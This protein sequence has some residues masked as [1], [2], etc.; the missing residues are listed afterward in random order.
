MVEMQTAAATATSVG[1]NSWLRP[2]E[3][4]EP[5]RD[6]SIIANGSAVDRM[7]ETQMRRLG[8]EAPN[9]LAG[10]RVMV[11]GGTGCVG[12]AVIARLS[13]LTPRPLIVSVSRG[14]TTPRPEYLH[15]QYEIGD[16]R[17]L[18]TMRRL[19]DRHRPDVILHLAAQ[20][21][22]GQAERR[23]LETVD[24]N[25]RGLANV[26]EAAKKAGVGRVVAASTGKAF[27][28]M[29]YD[30]YAFTKQLGEYVLAGASQNLDVA[31]ARFT[32]I[33]DNSLIWRKLHQWTRAGDPVLLHSKNAFYVQS[34]MEAADLL[35]ALTD[36]GNGVGL[37]IAAQRDLGESVELVRL[38]ADVRHRNRS[39]S[40]IEIV[41]HERGY[42]EGFYAGTY[43]VL[44]AGDH[45]P[46][47]NAI[48]V[49]ATDATD[50]DAQP[51]DVAVRPA[52]DQ[53]EG[54][55]EEFL[56]R[57]VAQSDEAALRDGIVKIS[58][59]L[60]AWRLQGA[61]PSTVERAI[62]AAARDELGPLHLAIDAVLREFVIST[63]S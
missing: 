37:R 15:V 26:I 14:L 10:M 61:R 9:H 27:R 7:I 49:D 40:P 42:E 13:K 52:G 6:L 43:D 16:V 30:V 39:Q 45:S 56:E 23:P 57:T 12:A 19:V 62:R 32:H 22:P 18:E 48:E 44:T 54:L 31:V 2:A 11:I 8:V 24:V 51:Y 33:V 28:L 58:P 21:D 38:A 29:T 63:Q 34:A 4:I 20:R 1:P 59:A 60:L 35:L 53:P 17:S 46:L 47:L 50:A 55:I 3:V 36:G 25:V 41:G 5:K